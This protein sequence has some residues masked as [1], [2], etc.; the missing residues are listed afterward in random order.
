M[1]ATP[2]RRS[3]RVC[4]RRC[5]SRMAKVAAPGS[6]APAMSSHPPVRRP[7]RAALWA[8]GAADF[9]Y[10]PG[11]AL[12]ED[13][14]SDRRATGDG[15]GRATRMG[16]QEHA[17]HLQDADHRRGCAEFADDRLPVPTIAVLSGD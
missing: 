8:N 11:I 2:P 17:R 16:G 3:R 13:L 4:A 9:V 14:W 15:L 12:H 6:D 10:D 1:S 7:V 5:W